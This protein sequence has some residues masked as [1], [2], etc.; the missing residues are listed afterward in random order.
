VVKEEQEEYNMAELDPIIKQAQEIDQAKKK[1]TAMPM[2]YEEPTI[3]PFNAPIPG[4]GL[5]DEPGN[6]PWEH[7]PQFPEIEDAA[8]FIYERLSDPK[9][10][11]R[12]LTMMRIGVPIEALV[13]VITFS[14]F[15]EGKFTVDVARLLEPIV[16]MQIMSK[17]Q[18]AEIPAKI[19]LEDTED[20]EFYKDM[21]KVKKSIDLDNLPMDKMTE[22][23]I[24]KESVK[25]LMEK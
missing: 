2:Q 11:K 20:T 25:G 12:L 3:N 7:P 23:K 14:G 9:Q 16:A 6:Y 5:T 4:Q 22:E 15:L 13:K 10:L 21:A 19:N 8:D 17:A 24:E 18:V 1:P